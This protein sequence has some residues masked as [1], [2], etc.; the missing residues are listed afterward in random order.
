[1]GGLSRGPVTPREWKRPPHPY[2]HCKNSSPQRWQFQPVSTS[3]RP[4]W[5]S[6]LGHEPSL[7]IRLLAVCS[8]FL[9]RHHRR[10]TYGNRETVLCADWAPPGPPGCDPH[11]L[12]QS[13]ASAGRRRVGRLSSGSRVACAGCH[14]CS[15][16]TSRSPSLWRPRPL[17]SSRARASGSMSRMLLVFL[18]GSAFGASPTAHTSIFWNWKSSWA[19][20]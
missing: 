10:W 13:Q 9:G 4:L 2:H 7:R 12:D 16:G 1:M 5:I 15:S 20:S 17:A 19:D 3:Q 11:A 14:H 18:T 8:G 6:S